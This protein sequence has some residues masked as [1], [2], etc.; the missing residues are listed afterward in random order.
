M[1]IRLQKLEKLTVEC[2]NSLREVFDFEGLVGDVHAA[3]LPQLSE[4]VL[5]KL[6]E[7]VQMWNKE[8]SGIAVFQNL[9]SLQ[10]IDCKSLVNL[11]SPST[12]RNLVQL[13][14]LKIFNCKQMKEV[15]TREVKSVDIVVFPELKCL[16]LK[17]L[18]NLTCFSQA[19]NT[20]EWPSLETVR[21]KD[22]PKMVNFA[23]GS[24]STPKLKTIY[25]TFLEKCWKGDLNTTIL[26]LYKRTEIQNGE[27]LGKEHG[28][29]SDMSIESHTSEASGKEQG[30]NEKSP[31]IHTGEASGKEQGRSNEMSTEIDTGEVLENEH[32]RSNQSQGSLNPVISSSQARAF[33][34][35]SSSMASMMK[36]QGIPQREIEEVE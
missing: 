19:N 33:D 5:T 4:L 11:F 29:S 15:I 24:Q 1:L 35:E 17:H 27:V 22:I 36:C 14:T 28:R 18:P 23:P 3:L 31:E 21:V 6:P 32:E 20:F 12:A 8:P 9:R 16:I 13:Q 7:F 26:H 2:C 10:I 30:S 25:V 34:A